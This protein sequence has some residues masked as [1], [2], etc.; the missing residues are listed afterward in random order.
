M[1]EHLT[2]EW[3]DHRG[4]KWDLTSGTEG[5]LLDV[6]QSDF[7]LSPIEHTYVRGGS[8]WAGAQVKRAEPSLKVLVADQ[9]TG[10]EYYRLADE[11][12]SLANSPFDMGVLRVTRSDGEVREL[13][14]RLRDTPG[15]EYP[16][17]PGAGLD[18]TPGEAWLLTSPSSY[19]SGPEQSVRFA[20]D[21]VAGEGEPFYGTRGYGW[22]LYIASATA[23]TDLFIANS[24]QGPVWLTWTL[25]GPLTSVRFGVEGG[26]LAYDGAIPS[27]EQ[28]VVST[29]PGDRYAIEAGSG[30]NRYGKLSGTFAPMPV[31]DRIPLTITAEGMTADS[32]VIVTAREQFARPF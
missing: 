11:W 6:D 21:V 26:V 14:A 23:A 25:V 12:W 24:G 5:V 3:I 7:T 19:W 30:E 10:T 17:D 9:K 13:A 31:G 16:Y 32:A 15:T 4:K 20:S 18:D 2:V 27:G 29:A 8:Q 22:P 28:V 1:A